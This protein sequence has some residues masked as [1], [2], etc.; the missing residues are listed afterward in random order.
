MSEHMGELLFGDLSEPSTE[1]QTGIRKSVPLR[2]VEKPL[3]PKNN[4]KPTPNTA[5]SSPRATQ[6][7]TTWISDRLRR[8]MDLESVEDPGQIGAI[9]QNAVGSDEIHPENNGL[10][11]TKGQKEGSSAKEKVEDESNL[12]QRATKNT[13]ITQ[14]EDK[15][16]GAIQESHGYTWK[17]DRLRRI[18][19]ESDLLGVNLVKSSTEASVA[20]NS[21]TAS[22]ANGVT[23]ARVNNGK[24]DSK[25]RGTKMNQTQDL[26]T[27]LADIKGAEVIKSFCYTCPWQCPTEVFVRDGKVVYTKGNPESPHNIGSR[28]AKGMASTYI[29]QDPDRLRY[30]ML[31]TNPKGQPGEFK[32]I[33]WDEAF[34][35][36]ADKLKEIK[37][38]YGAES[39]VYTC[40]HDPNTQFFRHL[41]GDLYGSPNN[42]THTSGCEM[43][44]RS[45]CLTLFGHLFPM[46]DFGNSRYIMLWGMNMLGANQGLWESRALIEAKKKGARLVVVD[47]NFT[48]TA[49]KADEWIPIKPGTDGAMALAMCYVI[50]NE[51]L[52]DTEFVSRYCEGFDGFAEHLQ[53]CGYTPEWAAD[54]TGI[55]AET[56]AR[57]AREFATSK[58][59]MSAIFKGSGYYTNGADAGRACYILNAICGEVDKPGNLHLK[60]WAPLGLPVS[61]PDEAKATN[62]A[63]PLHVA[64]GYPLAP[65]LPNARLPE[66]VINGNPYPVKA[67]FVQS[68]NPVMSDPDTDMMKEMFK[69]LELSVA[70]ELFMSETAIECDIVLPET[71]FYEHA[72]IRQGMYIDPKVVLCQ[73]AIEPLGESKP[74]YEIVKGI[75]DKMGWAEH[76]PY[77]KWEDWAEPMMENVPMSVSELKEKG[78][79]VGD[80]KYN[81]VPDGLPTPSGKIEIRSSAYSD[82]GFSPYPIY[83]ERSVIPD[84]EYP[85][86]LTHSKL[87]MH[88]NIVTQNNPLLMEICPENWV[89]INSQDAAKYGI[90]DDT[91]VLIE[92]PK[93]KIK[94]KVKV[95]EGLVPGCVSIRH[96]HGF[97]HWAMGSTAKGKGAHSNNLMESHTN[98]IT[99]ANCYNECKVRIRAAV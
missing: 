93:D 92:S 31:R 49:Q 38:N 95:T 87:S 57:L 17:S 73:P 65:D 82:A 51:E 1:T 62:D 27:R 11:N 13:E 34:T 84:S 41:L 16:T 47:P 72:E 94:I 12:L 26:G 35:Y 63:Q 96:G 74:L 91:Y 4:L 54:I 52:F 37:S 18:L 88:C 79:W 98:P 5:Q 8:I 81:R 19:G 80:R 78:F 61:I 53:S 85:L 48:E 42:Y 7:T 43:D 3:A 86:Q 39:V 10:S 97:G 45:A 21:D 9:I 44:R 2:T 24:V 22:T 30:P 25:Y 33:T 69:H 59:A 28:C 77:E 29:T 83:T 58:P 90:V 71:S 67:L 14:A 36:I 40:H 50:T 89:E 70:I 56:I 6:A 46:H 32:R 99:G 20:V 76:F 66:A 60:D 55:P 23:V 75:A 64:M 68:S 15:F